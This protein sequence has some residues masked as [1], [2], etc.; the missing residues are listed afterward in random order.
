MN[1]ISQ[2]RQ[3]ADTATSD[4]NALQELLKKALLAGALAFLTTVV[5][6]LT[7]YTK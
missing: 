5:A 1:N 2:F 7:D 6:G 3:V 4:T